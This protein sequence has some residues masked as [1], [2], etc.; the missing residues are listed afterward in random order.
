MSPLL[1]LRLVPNYTG[2]LLDAC[3]A[4]IPSTLL[5]ELEHGGER[6]L[7]AICFDEDLGNASAMEV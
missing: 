6:G 4:R 7:A 1:I 2:A 3:W 5:H